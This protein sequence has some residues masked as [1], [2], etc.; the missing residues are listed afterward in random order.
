MGH[1]FKAEVILLCIHAKHVHYSLLTTPDRVHLEWNP[2]TRM[3]ACDV[4]MWVW[5][6]SS[7]VHVTHYVFLNQSLQQVMAKH[8]LFHHGRDVAAVL[9]RDKRWKQMLKSSDR[10]FT[11]PLRGLICAMPGKIGI[12][13]VGRNE[14]T[15]YQSEILNTRPQGLLDQG[16]TSCIRALSL[17]AEVRYITHWHRLAVQS[18][19]WCSRI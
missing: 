6:T 19:H 5:L 15:S 9:L 4:C 16:C 7:R 8:T 17:G 18:L 10:E 3:F 2:H 11:T 1:L 13:C 14:K 12:F